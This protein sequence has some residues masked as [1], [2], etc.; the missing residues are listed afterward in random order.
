MWSG[1]LPAIPAAGDTIEIRGV[2]QPYYRVTGAHWIT[3][4]DSDSAAVTVNVEEWS[5]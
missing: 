2:E 4:A 1:T 5:P 3:Y